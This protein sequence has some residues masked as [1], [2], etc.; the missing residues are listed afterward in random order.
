MI[1]YLIDFRFVGTTLIKG[2]ARMLDFNQIEERKRTNPS[3]NYKCAA[4]LEQ[5]QH[6]EGDWKNHLDAGKGFSRE[7]GSP[8]PVEK[9]S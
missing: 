4:C 6:G 8:R 5:R 7:H 9:K 3:F 2:K 1:N